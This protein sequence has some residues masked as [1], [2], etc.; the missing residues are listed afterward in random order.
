MMLGIINE[1]ILRY[2]NGSR[3]RMRTEIIQF[4]KEYYRVEEAFQ[5]TP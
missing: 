3:G 5:G 1:V 4:L 2:C